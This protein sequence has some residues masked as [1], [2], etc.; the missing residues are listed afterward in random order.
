M[1]NSWVLLLSATLAACASAPV[2][3]RPNTLLQDNLF[4]PASEPITAADLFVLSPEMHA[5]LKTEEAA[6]P[7]YFQGPQQGLVTALYDKSRLKVDYDAEE[8]RDA[9]QTFAAGALR[10]ISRRLV[11]IARH[12]MNV[13]CAI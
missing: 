10:D 8:T 6:G 7:L 3:D 9:A 11:A 4:A 2:V 1:R 12:S 5:Y 13:A